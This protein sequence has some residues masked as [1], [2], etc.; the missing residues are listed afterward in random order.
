MEKNLWSTAGL[1]CAPC[2]P[3]FWNSL[4]AIPRRAQKSIKP[5]GKPTKISDWR[6]VL[7]QRCRSGNRTQWAKEQ[8]ESLQETSRQ[9]SFLGFP[10]KKT[11]VLKSKLYWIRNLSLSKLSVAVDCHAFLLFPAGS[12]TRT[13]LSWLPDASVPF[14]PHHKRWWCILNIPDNFQ[15]LEMFVLLE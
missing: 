5:E 3:N 14:E 7:S 13:L 1:L 11:K 12:A 15:K 10:T 6:H 8:M 4:F 9:W 2:E